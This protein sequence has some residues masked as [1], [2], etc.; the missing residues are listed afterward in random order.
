MAVSAA[1]LACPFVSP[2]VAAEP[3]QV[4]LLHSFGRDFKPWSDYARTIRQE[5]ERQS[6]WPVD[7]T[8]HAL[9]SARFSDENPEPVFVDY[10]WALF[11]RRPPDLI[12]S[13]GAPAAAFVQRN[14][15]RLFTTTPM[16]FTAVEQ[17]RVQLS[18]L[19]AND[20][21]V[22]VWINYRA[23]LENILQVLPDTKNIT[24]VVGTSPI[25]KFWKEAIGKEAEPL[26]GRVALS[27]TDHL[28]FE[29]LLKQAAALPPN[30]AI[31]WELMIVD[32]AGVVHEGSTPL[33]RLHATAN[34]P[35]FSYDESFF[36]NGLVGG[37]L[38][39]VTDTSRQ[40]AAIA[41]RILGG[42]K[43]G[44]IRM[45]PVEFAKP[46]F[47]WR[48]MQRW[49][50]SE[51]R[52]PPGSQVLFRELTVWERYRIQISTV[53]GLLL[54]QGALITWLI[55]EHWRRQSAEARSM[56]QMA[57]LARMNRLATAGQLSAA[58]AHE[59]RQ[60]LAAIASSGSAGLNWLNHEEPDLEEVRVN[61]QTVIKQS[62]RADDVI[63]GVRA[64]FSRGSTVRTQINLNELIE[65]VLM[66]MERSIATKNVALDT[67]LANDP[68]PLV[69]A[70]PVQLQQ[71][72][73]NLVLNAVEAMAASDHWARMLQIE[74]RIGQTGTVIVTVSD[75]G[76]GFDPKVVANL[77]SPFVT[78]KPQG[79]GMGLSICKSIIEQH[80]GQLTAVSIE[81]R[82]ALL[83]IVLPAAGAD[84]A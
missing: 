82:G 22:P 75:T 53:I 6:P 60:P 59:I 50:I 67:R 43:A 19:T 11:A 70:D 74:T 1:L 16:V 47:D 38:L 83:T 13:I 2:A 5:L 23:A 14:R 37:P 51:S 7:I 44:N 55:Y 31:F 54:I 17:R 78:T 36:G 73:L 27:W 84:Q 72:L 12:V 46:M 35:I 33:K 3:K 4:V 77:F 32:A 63:K 71:V 39:L 40:T 41:V 64:M 56:Q 34:A 24:V 10:L 49:G 66:L 65:Q 61:L 29:E 80:G 25:E 45:P 8:E 68:P 42:E 52:L 76:P 28:S 57:E 81:P 58:L 15:E 79:M 9:V 62:H 30:S 21:A 48:E 18:W 26:A 69:M 20:A